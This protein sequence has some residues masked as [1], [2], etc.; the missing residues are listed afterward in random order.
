MSAATSVQ[1]DEYAMYDFMS[2]G[3]G[4]WA[5]LWTYRGRLRSE[6]AIGLPIFRN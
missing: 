5:E 1:I 2:L 4:F 6:N 3:V